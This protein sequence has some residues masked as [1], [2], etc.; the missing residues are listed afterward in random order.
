[1]ERWCFGW[2]KTGTR[3]FVAVGLNQTMSA[4]DILDGKMIVKIGYAPSRPA[5]FIILEFKQMQQKS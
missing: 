4:Q 1:L 5:E 3:I 2:S